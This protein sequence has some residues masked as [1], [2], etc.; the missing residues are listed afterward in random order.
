M[1][2]LHRVSALVA[3]LFGLLTVLAGGR[4]LLGADPGY[5]VFRPLLVY[6]TVMGFVYVGAGAVIW[7]NV[8]PGRWAAGAIAFLNLAVLVGVVASHRTGGSVAM[9]SVRAMTFRTVVWIA[10]FLTVSWLHR[11]ER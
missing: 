8:A 9:Q 5:V 3:A 6:N 1:R 10:L 4:V 11:S 2:F 7:R